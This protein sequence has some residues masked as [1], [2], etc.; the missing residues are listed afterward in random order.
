[1][2]GRN[3]MRSEFQ[4]QFGRYRRFHFVGIGGIGMSGIAEILVRSG[5]EVSGSD[6]SVT[7]ITENLRLLGIRVEVGHEGA[8]LGQAQVLVVSSA[9]REENPERREAERRGIPIVHRADM[10][11][12][13]IRRK[14]GITVC[15]THG[16]TT[17]TSMAAL[18][19]IEAGLDPTVVN[20]ARLEQLS[21]NAVRGDGRY[22]VAEADES[23][24]SFLK[25][26]PIYS[27]VTNIDEDHLDAYRDMEH[28]EDSFLE[29]MNR[30]PFH[31]AVIGCLD[32]RRLAPLLQKI[33]T[34]VVTYGLESQ[35]DIT[36]RN[37][38][39]EG[40]RTGYECFANGEALGTVEIQVPGR[41]N[42]LNSLAV[43]ALGLELDIAF[44]VIRRA[45]KD[46]R[47]AER[48]LERKG[49][50]DGVLVVDDYGHHP[51]E[52]QATLSACRSLRRRICAVYQPHRFSRTQNLMEETADCF[53][54]ADRVFLLDVYAAGEDPIEGVDSSRLA[55]A[56]GV[57][58]EVTYVPENEDIQAVLKRELIPGDLLLTIGAGSVWKV[59][60]EF[61]ADQ[62]KSR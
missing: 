60:E 17:T 62:E 14:D 26:S 30:V 13:L 49:E 2:T 47:G 18:V 8:Y 34:R 58:R 31:G 36:A 11:A 54:D 22:L 24:R 32:D 45:L 19:L 21:S 51:V 37:L 16:K 39:S 53:N 29:H 12:E 35:A 61:L 5:Y 55:E 27:I 42:V 52:I 56:I 6:L 41:H 57:R 43:V 20:G 1:M 15:G 50:R 28:L 44:D 10:L 3:R 7:P 59:G 4:G 23:D 46:F 33:H 25:F 40:F 9:I 48:R 38:W